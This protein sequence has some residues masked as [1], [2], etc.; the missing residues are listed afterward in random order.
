MAA[1]DRYKVRYQYV[2]FGVNC[3]NVFFYQQTVGPAG[4]FN[5]SAGF[6]ATVLPAI[7]A[8]L[9]VAVTSSQVVVVNEDDVLDFGTFPII[10]PGTRP[11]EGLSTFYSWGFTYF[12]TDRRV[13]SGG[14]RFAG[15]SETDVAAGEETPTARTLLDS[16]AVVL[17]S[18]FQNPALTN[19]Y[20]PILYTP[21]NIKTG[22]LPVEVP[23]LGVSYRRLTTQST[24]KNF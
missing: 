21:G 9:S 15:L 18:S 4:A 6:L 13:R 10:T 7:L 11:G 23:L 5:L 8:I 2:Y 20:Q 16:L 24:R 12:S 3:E 17:E 22:G 1:G 19:T 14:K